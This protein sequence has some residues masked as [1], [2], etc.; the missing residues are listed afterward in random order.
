[1]LKKEFFSTEVTRKGYHQAQ[2]TQ[3]SSV[4]GFEHLK[5]FESKGAPHL[6][7]ENQLHAQ[8]FE[9]SQKLD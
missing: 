8:V 9:L 2:N 5:T 7:E 1:M 3:F 4:G 6:D